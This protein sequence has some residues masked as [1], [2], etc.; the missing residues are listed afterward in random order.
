MRDRLKPKKTGI[1]A[2]FQP[3][4]IRI[5]THCVHA[6]R[7]CESF[8]YTSISKFVVVMVE[9]LRRHAALIPRSAYPG[10]HNILLATTPEN[11]RGTLNEA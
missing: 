1:S 2:F 5:M 9:D 3:Q 11:K 7:T 4:G 10:L 6:T 8:K